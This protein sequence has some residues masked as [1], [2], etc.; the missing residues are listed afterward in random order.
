MKIAEALI[1]RSDLNKK[2]LSL[3][4]RIGSYSVV[5]EGQTPH[6][7]P[8]VLIKQAVGVIDELREMM[9]SI[10]RANQRATIAD[11]ITIAE[12]LAK[13]F[14][15]LQQHSMLTGAIEGSKKEPDR[16]SAREIKWIATIDVAGT[17]K[18][19]EDLAKKIRDLNIKIQE[20]NWKAEL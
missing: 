8:V 18:Q 16:Y 17:Q 13:R 11:G 6:E 2:L 5:Q 9:V 15:Y 10:D 19:I 12:A 7:D 20:A 3:R 4:Q 1:L 14:A